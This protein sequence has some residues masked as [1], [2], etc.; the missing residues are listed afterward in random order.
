MFDRALPWIVTA[1]IIIILGFIMGGL[2]TS[3]QDEREIEQLYYKRCVQTQSLG[4]CKMSAKYK[5]LE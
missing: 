3:C 2:V 1:V 5:V 4:Q